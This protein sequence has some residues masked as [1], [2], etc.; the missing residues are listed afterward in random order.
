MQQLEHCTV[1]VLQAYIKAMVES[2][3]Q[4]AYSE[5]TIEDPLDSEGA[6]RISGTFSHLFSPAHI[7]G[8]PVV[9]PTNHILP[10][11]GFCQVP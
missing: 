6:S 7:R 8:P 11:F 4:V 5:G 10:T 2:V 1:R 3:Q 9:R